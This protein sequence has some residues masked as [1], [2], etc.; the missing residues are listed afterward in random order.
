MLALNAKKELAK[1]RR[2]KGMNNMEYST[3]LLVSVGLW[4]LYKFY[5]THEKKH[6]FSGVILI[7]LQL[8]MWPLFL[9]PE[10]T[11]GLVILFI[12][13]IFLREICYREKKKEYFIVSIVLL[14]LGIFFTAD[15]V[16]FKKA[17]WQKRKALHVES[18]S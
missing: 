7:L 17:E 3:V 9:V 18:K 8:S 14:A 11:F 12:A 16:L 10:I 1:A 15:G 6:L 5:R 2:L 13:G 4:L